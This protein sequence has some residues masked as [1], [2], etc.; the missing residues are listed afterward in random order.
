MVAKALFAARFADRVLADEGIK[1]I[2]AVQEVLIKG[3]KRKH[4]KKVLAK[5]D[6]GAWRTSISESLAEE[7]GL[8]S[9]NNVLWTRRVRSSLGVQNRPVISLTFW[10][11]GTKVTTPASVAKR[12]ALK[13]PVIIGRKNLKGFLIKPHITPQKRATMDTKKSNIKET[14]SK[15]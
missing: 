8:L 6:T 12:M 7:L 3:S 15:N 10:M 11:A 1:T 14:K 4:R 13:Y 5:V 9:P 2:S